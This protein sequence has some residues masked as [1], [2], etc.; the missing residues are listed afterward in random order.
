MCHSDVV[1]DACGNN[2]SLSVTE[3]DVL[4]ISQFCNL[5]QK[6]LFAS[7]SVPM[8]LA[9]WLVLLKLN[10]WGQFILDTLHVSVKTLKESRSGDVS[11][12]NS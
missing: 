9:V 6:F 2:C 8:L 10:H 12:G 5:K 3:M 1:G 11:H 7:M 4:V